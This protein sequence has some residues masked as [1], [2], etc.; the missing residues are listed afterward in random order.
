MASIQMARAAFEHR[1][2]R[3]KAIA[4]ASGLVVATSLAGRPTRSA[5]QSTPA[6]T[7]VGTPAFSASPFSLG[8]A[9]GDP[10]PDSV[11]LWTRLAPDPLAADGQGGMPNA[12]VEV[13]WEIAP[14]DGFH[15]IVQTGS[16]TASPTLAHSVHVDA[17]GLAPGRTYFYR[18]MAGGEVSP[19]G[20]TRTA[21]AIGSPVD[22]LRFAF[23]SCQNYES[24]YFTSY[25]HIVADDPDMVIFLGDYIYEN[26]GGQ[27]PASARAAT[28][29]TLR[30]LADFRNRYATYKGD[31]DLQAAHAAVPWVLTWDDHEVTNDY[32]GEAVEDGDGNV[33]SVLDLR[34]NAYQAYNEHQPL[35]PGSLPTGPDMQLYRRLTWGDLA[36]F[37]VLDTRQYRTPFPS[38]YGEQPRDAAAFD[39]STTITGPDQERWLLDGLDHS[40]ARWNVI[41][42]QVLM[43][44][45]LHQREPEIYWTDAW[46][47]Y[48]AARNRILSHLQT[49]AV[50]NP[51][52]I[53]G[54][55]HS[56]FVNELR[57][58]FEDETSPTIAAEFVVSSISS[59]GDGGGYQD[60]YGPMIPLNPHI[61]LF[62]GDRRGYQ[63][64][65]VTPDE[66]RVDLQMVDTVLSET[67]DASTF[68]SF[69]LENGN[70]TVRQL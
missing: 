3:R 63:R 55:W 52:V 37:Q 54:D 56:T 36:E 28:G 29:G 26:A 23:A 66:W 68:A 48:P 20:R 43:A 18:F 64:V 50:S 19:I 25:P 57:A 40:A 34:T 17:T 11:V 32:S 31:G 2:T 42:Q 13:R 35:R 24:G 21:P 4:A 62:D 33:I 27:D 14:D 7:P 45:L 9:S 12:P 51:V 10:M 38:G 61:R 70:P 5:A 39:P 22:R 1:L 58:N 16:S 46:D 65:E 49:G 67:A 47:G 59:N 53:T 15:Q 69:V 44:E 60:Y 41:A 8:V 30:T 6:A